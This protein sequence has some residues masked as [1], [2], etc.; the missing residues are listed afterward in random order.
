[1]GLFYLSFIES[2]QGRNWGEGWLKK[3]PYPVRS[4]KYGFFLKLTIQFETKTEN[5]L[6]L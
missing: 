4:V 2:S 3:S 1:M 5:M 6:E